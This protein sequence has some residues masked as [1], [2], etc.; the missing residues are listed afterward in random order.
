MSRALH[1]TLC[2]WRVQ[3]LRLAG[4]GDAVRR[5]NDGRRR[6]PARGEVTL[7]LSRRS[8]ARV[9]GSRSCSLGAVWVD[10]LVR[11]TI[12]QRARTVGTRQYL[13][14]C[15]SKPPTEIR[16][17][18]LSAVSTGCQHTDVEI[19]SPWEL[20]QVCLSGMRCGHDLRLP[21]RHRQFGPTTS[22]R[23]GSGSSKSGAGSRDGAARPERLPRVPRNDPS[24]VPAT[25][26]PW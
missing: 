1:G 25:P 20:A 3:S 22:G 12:R 19:L 14:S 23:M 2:D 26:K 10:E 15:R 13:W 16:G 5:R 24:G 11:R 8:D 18:T 9:Q 21:T 17:C 6:R 7:P 4:V